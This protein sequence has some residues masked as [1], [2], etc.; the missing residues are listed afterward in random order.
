[1]KGRRKTRAETDRQ[2][3]RLGG[4]MFE[5]WRA[6]KC[7]YDALYSRLLKI[8]VLTRRSQN[9]V[10]RVSGGAGHLDDAE[11]AVKSFRRAQLLSA[12]RKCGQ[13]LRYER[14]ERLSLPKG[15][16]GTV[17]IDEYKAACDR[18]MGSDELKEQLE[19]LERGGMDDGQRHEAE[20]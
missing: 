15:L 19:R 3:R 13:C 1:M 14:L 11:R 10:I 2:A 9:L 12:T 8:T 20:G 6:G 16:C 18:F 4:R 17:V 5:R 7:S